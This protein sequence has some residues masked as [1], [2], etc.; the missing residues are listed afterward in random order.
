M[1]DQEKPVTIDLNKLEELV[2]ERTNKEIG[3]HIALWAS[4]IGLTTLGAL[5][6]F[7]AGTVVYIVVF[8]NDSIE[9]AAQEQ[10]VAALAADKLQTE[11]L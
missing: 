4:I 10:V 1:A 7:V 2:K 11:A 6:S 9:K 3:R 5:L 8:L